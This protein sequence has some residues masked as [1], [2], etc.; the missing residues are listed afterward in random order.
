MV[1]DRFKL[2]NIFKKYRI[3]TACHEANVR[4]ERKTDV[5]IFKYFKTACTKGTGP[6]KD[7]F[8]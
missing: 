3:L 2:L 7:C 1:V 5:G 6:E 4:F 8:L